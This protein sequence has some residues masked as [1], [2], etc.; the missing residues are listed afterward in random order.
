MVSISALLTTS[1]STRGID[2]LGFQLTNPS[3]AQHP[4]EDA[5]RQRNEAQAKGAGPLLLTRDGLRAPKP[6]PQQALQ[7]S[8]PA[9]ED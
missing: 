3:C 2:L 4:G 6:Q 9:A 7:C 5:E 1:S 8:L